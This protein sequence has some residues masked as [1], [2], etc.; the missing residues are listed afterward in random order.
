[1]FENFMP[2][3]AF[4]PGPKRFASLVFT[5]YPDMAVPLAFD[6]GRKAGVLPQNANMIMYKDAYVYVTLAGLTDSEGLDPNRW[7]V[8]VY[9]INQIM[10]WELLAGKGA[11][12]GISTSQNFVEEMAKWFLAD[13][14]GALKKF[15][16]HAAT[17]VGH[18][19]PD[20]SVLAL[21]IDRAEQI[22]NEQGYDQTT[23]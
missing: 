22:M 17:L 21:V 19:L 1:M 18:I 20:L 14:N 13:L 16:E 10:F 9:T 6:R 12:Y 23:H 2:Y 8:V 3:I 11:D 15:S 5:E 4:F 7:D